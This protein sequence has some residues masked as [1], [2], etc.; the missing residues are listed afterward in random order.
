MSKQYAMTSPCPQ[1]PFRSDIPPF[2][3]AA[4][5]REIDQSLVRGEFPC[6]KTVEYDDDGEPI[7]HVTNESHCA[8]A[9]ILLEKIGR[10]SQMMRIAGRLGMYDRRKLNMAAPVFESFLAMEKAMKKARV[11]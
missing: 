1:C 10:P 11:P 9:L 7:R 4:R 6:H 3:T 2:L 8:G 5:V